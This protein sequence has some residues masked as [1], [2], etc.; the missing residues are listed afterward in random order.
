M[1]RSNVRASGKTTTKSRINIKQ[2][3]ASGLISDQRQIS[4]EYNTTISP[5]VN[6]TSTS[7]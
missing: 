5:F 4:N 2:E 7:F 6:I 1:I 3:T